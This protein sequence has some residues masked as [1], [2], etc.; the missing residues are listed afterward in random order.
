MSWRGAC[1]R[2]ERIGVETLFQGDHD[3]LPLGDDLAGDRFFFLFSPFF[4]LFFLRDELA[5]SRTRI[6]V[7]LILTGV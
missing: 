3:E 2:G 5:Q 1:H 7:H 6:G 4:I